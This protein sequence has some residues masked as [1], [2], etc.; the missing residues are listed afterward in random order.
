MFPFINII[1]SLK[2]RR[3]INIYKFF[4]NIID[5]QKSQD[6]TN[7]DHKNLEKNIIKIILNVM[8]YNYNTNNNHTF[9]PFNCQIK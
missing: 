4:L 9:C 5:I 7:S 8:Q 1:T 6:H 2:I 3:Y